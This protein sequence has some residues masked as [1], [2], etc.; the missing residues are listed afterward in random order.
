MKQQKCLQAHDNGSSAQK[1][2]GDMRKQ[3]KLIMG[4][5]HKIK[6]IQNPDARVTIV[7]EYTKKHFPST[8]ILDFALG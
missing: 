3:N 8:P 6:S 2:V 1:F 5:G 4:M 7:K